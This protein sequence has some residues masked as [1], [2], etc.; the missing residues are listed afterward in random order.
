MPGVPNPLQPQRNHQSVSEPVMNKLNLFV[1]YAAAAACDVSEWD[2]GENCEGATAGTRYIRHFFDSRTN[3]Y[4]YLAVN[5]RDRRII[6]GSRGAVSIESWTQN[7]LLIQRPVKWI[8]DQSV[9]IH[10]GFVNC[11][12]GLKGEL[13]D[14]LRDIVRQYPRYTPTFIGHSM[15]G[16]IVTLAALHF[17]ILEISSVQLELYTF[18]EPQSGNAAFSKLINKR[19]YKPMDQSANDYLPSPLHVINYNDII[20]RLPLRVL[21]YYFH[22]TE[23]WIYSADGMKVTIC[24]QGQH[25]G[26]PTCSASIIPLPDIARHNHYFGIGMDSS[27]NCKAWAPGNGFLHIGAPEKD[28]DVS[29]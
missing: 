12:H 1:R 26:D 18:G 13:I 15:G 27:A 28:T 20:P 5:D 7:M 14:A 19:L 8:E 16:A 22:D 4:A 6:I 10:A 11:Y 29:L 9:R 2:C 23:A 21:N 24:E 17:D 3:A 25:R